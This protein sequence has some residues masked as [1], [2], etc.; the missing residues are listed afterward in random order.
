MN[1][2]G[3]LLYD[4]RDIVA[5]KYLVSICI[6][7]CNRA[8]YLR[9][10]LDSLV[11]QPEF[12]NGMVEIVISDNASTDNTGDLVK[13]YT[14]KYTNITYHRNV[15]NMGFINGDV[16]FAVAMQSGHGILRKLGGDTR[17]YKEGSLKYF[18]EISRR[19]KESRPVIYFSNGNMRGNVQEMEEI[20]T[21]DGFLHGASFWLTWIDTVCLWEEECK[22]LV[23]FAEKSKTG[24]WFVE[25]TVELMEQKKH[26]IFFNQNVIEG[27]VVKKKDISYG[28]F[29]VF[30]D[31][32]LGIFRPMV[33]RGVITQN[34]F[35]YLEKD[36]LFGFFLYFVLEWELS[37][38]SYI[39]SGKEDLKEAVWNRYHTK[40][41]FKEFSLEYS[42]QYSRARIK[43]KIK[44]IPVLGTMLVKLKHTIQGW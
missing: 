12:L 20:V 4:K 22:D 16:N 38:D 18:C 15:V 36:L 24:F 17:I 30:Y 11:C 19:W 44:A 43:R 23:S 14:K 1:L 35:D 3:G 13:K 8:P 5:D 2:L 27:M 40:S 34:C 6:P 29:G 42:K 37:R 28:I 32:F 21:M 9:K 26:V 39:F 33:G 25:K 7:T 31:K 41:Y 10:C